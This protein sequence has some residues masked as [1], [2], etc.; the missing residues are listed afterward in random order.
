ML[1][2]TFALDGGA[3]FGVVPR[4]V[5]AREAPPDDEGRIALALRCLLIAVDDR[6]I[7]V[8]TGIGGGWSERD[9][10]RY[11]I[12][13][14]DDGLI[15]SLGRMGVGREAITDVV[16][17]HLH[18]DHAG[19]VCLSDGQ[20]NLGL[21]FPNARHHLQRR[22]LV[23]ALH[24]TVRD[25]ASYLEDRFR[26]MIGSRQLVLHDG[27]C[28]LAAGVD[29]LLYEGHTVGQQLV[30][31]R[32]PSNPR[33]WLL[34]SADIIPTS[35]HLAQAFVMGYDLLPDVTAREKKRILARAEEDGGLLVFEHDPKIA[36]ARIRIDAKGRPVVD[37]I[38]ERL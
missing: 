1:D 11:A 29:L 8:D 20:G 26:P 22:N 7:L 36:A 10:A 18:F 14:P 12:E 5:W 17:T 19:G 31:V 15:G 25:R 32:D 33:S 30:R 27:P 24:P 34:Y 28:E 4:S 23:H 21:S 13:R 6:L 35:A 16:L 37:S 3:M 38:F 9:G 2:G